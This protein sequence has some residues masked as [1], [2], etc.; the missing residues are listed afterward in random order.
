MVEEK[1][2]TEPISLRATPIEKE[3][4]LGLIK[5]MGLPH[6][7]FVSKFLPIIK[8]HVLAQ[9]GIPSVDITEMDRS[10]AC[11]PRPCSSTS[12]WMPAPA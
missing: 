2:I 10:R 1:R 5:E 9:K 3:E 4:L 8:A 6:D 11:P 7:E 12:G